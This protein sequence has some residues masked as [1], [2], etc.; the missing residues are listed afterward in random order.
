MKDKKYD[1][2][3]PKGNIYCIKIKKLKG[4]ESTLK[5]K[6]R[7]TMHKVEKNHKANHVH[8]MSTNDRGRLL[9]GKKKDC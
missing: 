9:R 3:G 8:K 5:M 7:L 2:D 1:H 6:L 4:D